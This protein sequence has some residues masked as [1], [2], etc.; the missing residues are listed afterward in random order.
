MYIVIQEQYLL[1]NCEY[2]MSHLNFS[3]TDII[4]RLKQ[5]CSLK[6][7]VEC[8][9][10]FGIHPSTLANWKTRN[11]IRYSAIVQKCGERGLNLHYI[12]TGEGDTLFQPT[13]SHNTTEKS[14]QNHLPH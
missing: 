6:T 7:D 4:Y 13:T 10:F 11:T 14:Q 8:A 2:A 9:R 1:T 5:A 3:T 12:L